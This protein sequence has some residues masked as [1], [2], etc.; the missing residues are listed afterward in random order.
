[1]VG[2][3][4]GFIELQVFLGVDEAPKKRWVRMCRHTRTFAALRENRESG[5]GEVGWVRSQLHERFIHVPLPYD[6][7]PALRSCSRKNVPGNVE[8][9]S[10]RAR[11]KRPNRELRMENPIN[12]VR[13]NGGGGCGGGCRREEAAGVRCR[14]PLGKGRC[15]M[16]RWTTTMA[17]NRRDDEQRGWACL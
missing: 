10:R 9:L 14:G 13:V 2:G 17:E 7:R 8:Q 15:T 3:R 12:Q 5:I 1:M 16:I 6:D 11:M 4:G